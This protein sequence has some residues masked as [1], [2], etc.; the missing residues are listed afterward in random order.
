MSTTTYNTLPETEARYLNRLKRVSELKEDNDKELEEIKALSVEM[1][2]EKIWSINYDLG[3]PPFPNY[4]EK[5]ALKITLKKLIAQKY[6]IKTTF[7]VFG[8]RTALYSYTVKARNKAD[9]IEMA[10]N[11]EGEYQYIKEWECLNGNVET[12]DNQGQEAHS[13]DEDEKRM[14]DE[15]FEDVYGTG[16]W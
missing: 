13:S 9:A 10:K 16:D 14:R 12:V 15:I 11:G 8:E 2:E 5:R 4:E 3:T 7:E 1:L 6:C